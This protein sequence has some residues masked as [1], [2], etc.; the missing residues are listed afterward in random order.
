MACPGRAPALENPA[1]RLC[2]RSL[3]VFCMAILNIPE[4]LFLLFL[5][6]RGNAAF[7]TSKLLS[8]FFLFASKQTKMWNIVE[9]AF[10][11]CLR[12]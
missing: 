6:G 9:K 8:A 5:V 2:L 3:T 12:L 7:I 10:N 4:R 11:L 1:T